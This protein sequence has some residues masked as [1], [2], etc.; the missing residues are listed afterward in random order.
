MAKT[1]K[2]ITGNTN[3]SSGSVNIPLNPVKKNKIETNKFAKKYKKELED[4]EIDIPY[5]VG[6]GYKTKK[7]FFDRNA[8]RITWVLIVMNVA[9]LISIIVKNV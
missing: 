5:I 4:I 6:A 9:I 1:K 3:A 7:S 8:D 2:K